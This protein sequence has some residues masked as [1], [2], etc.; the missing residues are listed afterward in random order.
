[1][2][3]KSAFLYPD[4]WAI[5]MIYANITFA[6]G[7]R[8]HGVTLTLE[9]VADDWLTKVSQ[10]CSPY[11]HYQL[12]ILHTYHGKQTKKPGKAWVN[13]PGWKYSVCVITHHYQK[14]E[15][16]S[17]DSTMGED[18]QDSCLSWTPSFCA[19]SFDNFNLYSF[20]VINC[21]HKYNCCPSPLTSSK[22]LTL[23]VV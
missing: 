6:G 14:I 18:K 4:P 2:L 16:Y 3:Y 5:H 9:G 19:F 7:L 15:Y 12:S 23:R 22:S 8:P 11:P 21:N 20:T 17:H 13:N 10:V 1:M